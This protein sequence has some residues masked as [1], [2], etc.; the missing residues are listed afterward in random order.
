MRW[1]RRTTPPR[2]ENSNRPPPA[3]GGTQQ[4][5]PVFFSWVNSAVTPK[6]T[7]GRMNRSE[8]SKSGRDLRLANQLT[9]D[10]NDVLFFSMEQ[11]RLEMVLKSFTRRMAQKNIDSSVTSL[12]IRKG[13]L[14]QP[15]KDVA[16][17]Y[18]RDVGDRLSIIEGNFNCNI[19]FIGDYIRQYVSR[20][21]ADSGSSASA[22]GNAEAV[23]RQ[24]AAAA[25]KMS[26]WVQA[27][28]KWYNGGIKSYE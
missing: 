4:F 3:P 25:D 6:T 19:S 14:T 7:S 18:K 21:G 20:N 24:F 17:E 28:R 11:S 8:K 27:Y 12:S 10:G 22:R 15:V 1:Q 26:E 13:H 23:H 2:F 9:A 5:H 16:K